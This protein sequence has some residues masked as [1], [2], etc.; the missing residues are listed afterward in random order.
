MY[1]GKVAIVTG[2]GSGI[3]RC[4]CLE[5]ARRGA[6][7]VAVADLSSEAAAETV[8]LIEQAGG[9]A[10]AHAVDVTDADAVRRLVADVADEHGRLDYMINNAGTSVIGEVRDIPLSQWKRV[11]DVNLWGVIHGTTAA[12][13]RMLTQGNGHIVNVASGFGITPGPTL[14]PYAAS[15]HAVVGLST[16][17]RAEATDLGVK[18]SVVCPG[19]IQTTMLEKSATLGAENA[20]VLRNIPFK[21]CTA[22]DCARHALDGVARNRAI[23][24]FPFYMRLLT[25]IYHLFPGI[26]AFLVR[27]MVRDFRKIRKEK[28]AADGSHTET[29]L[30]QAGTAGVVPAGANHG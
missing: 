27:Q 20:D 29:L 5:L 7:A 21:L 3:G 11:I 13:A 4:L 28:P 24:A 30:P 14:V 1:Q 16:S 22:E 26:S 19:Y 17:L 2:G 15:K 12:Y 6:H 10:S 23:I 25:F 18:V 8:R 9:R